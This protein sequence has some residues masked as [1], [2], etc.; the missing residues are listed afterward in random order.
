VQKSS[1]TVLIIVCATA[2]FYAGVVFDHAFGTN[3]TTQT[4]A[5]S[6]IDTSKC[7]HN[8]TRNDFPGNT[9]LGFACIGMT[10]DQVRDNFGNPSQVN[11]TTGANSEDEQ[12]V[13]GN[14]ILYLSNGR[15]TYF[16]DERSR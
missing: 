14:Q 16:Q 4:Q 9:A 10:A 13:Y 1:K 11:S 7:I 5:P 12:W 3:T 15:L 6:R 8:R 2:L